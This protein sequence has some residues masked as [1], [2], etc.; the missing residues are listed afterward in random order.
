MIIGAGDAAQILIN[1]IST[2]KHFAKSKVVCAI[3]DDDTKTGKY[4]NGIRVA[5]TRHDI[6]T[7][8][9]KYAIDII[10]FAMWKI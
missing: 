5:G 6:I 8:A 7:C 2:N 4:I 10:V 9:K 1:D 3:D